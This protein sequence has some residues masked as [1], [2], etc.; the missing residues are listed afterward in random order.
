MPVGFSGSREAVVDL[1]RVRM[2][3][4]SVSRNASVVTHFGAMA[5]G[6]RAVVALVRVR[7][8]CC[9]VMLEL[10]PRSDSGVGR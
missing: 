8:S 7:A 10:L 3:C 6:F 5:V 9:A 4:L 2:L 1:F